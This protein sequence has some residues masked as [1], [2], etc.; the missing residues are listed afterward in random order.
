MALVVLVS[1]GG[2]STVIYHA[3]SRAGHATPPQPRLS[4]AREHLDKEFGA[5]IAVTPLP[6]GGQL[7]TYKYRRP[8]PKAADMARTSGEIHLGIGYLTQGLGWV[9][10][11]PVVELMLT[12]MAIHRAANPPRGEVLFTISPDGLLLSY[13]GPPPY[14]PEDPAVEAPSVGAIR[15]GCQAFDEER[16]YVECVVERFAVWSI[17]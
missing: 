15:Q 17:E 14:G 9:L 16:A 12:P 4:L 11:S 7:A 13:G 5:P 8:D 10:I 3:A 1:S 6:D 2:C